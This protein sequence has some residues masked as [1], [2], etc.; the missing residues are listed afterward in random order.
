MRTFGLL[1]SLLGKEGVVGRGILQ[2]ILTK[3][4]GNDDGDGAKGGDGVGG[5]VDNGQGVLDNG[6]V[7][8]V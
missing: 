2:S 8:H 5:V 3:T 4:F 6:I 7:D 1:I